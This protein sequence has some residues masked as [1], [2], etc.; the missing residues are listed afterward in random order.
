MKLLDRIALERF[1][2]II[3]S[4]ILTV[5]KLFIPPKTGGIDPVIKPNRKWKPRWRKEKNDE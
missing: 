5:I 3:L 1:L 2:S 4:F